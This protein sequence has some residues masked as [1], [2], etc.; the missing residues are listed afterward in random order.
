[1]ATNPLP[2]RLRAELFTQLAQLE[3]SGLPFD[4]SL[5]LLQI[6][7]D[8]AARLQAMK[9]RVAR[10]EV[11]AMAGEKSGVFTRLEARLIHAA[12]NAGSPAGV[13]RRLAELYTQRAMQLATMKSRMALPAIVLLMALLIQPLPTL[14]SGA[15]GAGGYLFGVV[16]PLLAIALALFLGRLL[17]QRMAAAAAVSPAPTPLTGLPLIG[18]LL[19]R[20]N[21]RDFLQSLALMLEAG[22]SMLDALPLA[23]DT[24]GIGAIRHQF[25]QLKPR[26]E[27]G[28]TLSQALATVT[29]LVALDSGARA[30]EFARTG[31]QSGTL[32]E[33]LLRHVALE[34][35][36]VDAFYQQAAQWLPRI[37]YGVIAL[38]MAL[39][40]LT[41]GAFLPNVPKN[42]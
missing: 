2:L 7:G 24:I 28:E 33:M 4:R 10:G 41:S 32:P 9:Q 37:V 35:A 29:V 20:Q 16:K 17:W 3:T 40:I 15:I 34:T 25:A 22:I 31:E 36:A 8:G 39:G 19:V 18:T 21:I 12:W 30:V 27:R 38:W 1:M 42:L 5:A 13:Y 11:L 26:I 6:G 23:L 14:V